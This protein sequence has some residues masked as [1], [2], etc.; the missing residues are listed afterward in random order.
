MPVG[1]K[2]S[3]SAAKFKYFGTTLTNQNCMQEMVQ[4]IKSGECLL[5]SSLEYF[6]LPFAI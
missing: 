2:S 4:K 1:S 3:T 5:P 6:I